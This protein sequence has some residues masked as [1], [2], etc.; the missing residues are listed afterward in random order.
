MMLNKNSSYCFFVDGKLE[1]VPDQPGTAVGT[2]HFAGNDLSF[3]VLVDLAVV[4]ASPVIKPLRT[5]FSEP[6]KESV[7]GA[8]ADEECLGSLQF[9]YLFLQ[10]GLNE[11]FSLTSVSL[12]RP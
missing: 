9:G 3:H 10:Y 5:L 8:G 2:H 11:F 6:R 12:Y 7:D 4:A 1:E